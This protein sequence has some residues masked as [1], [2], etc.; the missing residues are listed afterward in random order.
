MVFDNVIDFDHSNYFYE[1]WGK[2]DYFYDIRTFCATF[3]SLEF[4]MQ[5]L[6]HLGSFML[7]WKGPERILMLKDDV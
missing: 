3:E 6:G 5:F 4:T 1:I 2:N 7:L